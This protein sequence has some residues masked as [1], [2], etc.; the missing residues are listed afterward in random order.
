MF[1]VTNVS[2]VQF[3]QWMGKNTGLTFYCINTLLQWQLVFIRE[4]GQETQ[5]NFRIQ[6]MCLVVRQ[7]TH[8]A[9]MAHE[10]PWNMWKTH[11]QFSAA[12]ETCSLVLI[13]YILQK[14]H[15][16]KINHYSPSAHT[17]CSN[18]KF[19]AEYAEWDLCHCGIEH[20]HIADIVVQVCAT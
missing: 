17:Q 15:R 7:P 12:W 14:E 3:S 16:K 13:K 2:S 20:L 6:Q 1:Y 9:A 19:C 5:N 4:N 10:M 18:I 11:R 8:S